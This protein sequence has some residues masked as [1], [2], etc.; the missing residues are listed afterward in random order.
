[1]SD[2]QTPLKIQL[3]NQGWRQFLMAREE[4]LAAYDRA[5]VHSS[6]RQVQVEHGNVAEAEFR[7]WLI[8]FLPK[9]YGVTS[10]YIVSQGIP[11]SEH[12]VHYDVIIYD[13][14]ESP[15]LWVEGN[16]DDSLLGRSM[17]IPVE[18]VC[19]VIE[20]KAVFNKKSAAQAVEHLGRLRPLMGFSKP[21]I[22]DYR[23]YLPKDFFCATVFFE[24]H[25]EN[26]KDFAA[27]DALLDGSDLR[28]FYG[29]YILRPES[30]EEYS[31]GKIAFELLD[32]EVEHE[33]RSLLFWAYSRCKKLGNGYLRARL[34]H[35]ESNFSEFAF[36]IIALLKGKYLP[37]ALSSMYGQGTT[38]WENGSAVHTT[39]VNP[40]DKK[41]FDEENAKYFA[42]L[43]HKKPES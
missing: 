22:H 2:Q 19:G 11:N 37:Y 26:E 17:A 33:N 4:M 6:R 14:L 7:K 10:G 21:S 32:R 18:Y 28:G 36:D 16:P 43:Q 23:F 30:H 31:S 15:V 40:E 38:G 35:S 12:M 34:T 42:G 39:Y 5:R 13:Q 27:L 8:N 20:V 25:R 24:L 29:G 41:R 9:R 1:M 3:P